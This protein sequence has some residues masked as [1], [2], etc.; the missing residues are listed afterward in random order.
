MSSRVKFGFRAGKFIDQGP[1]EITA[2]NA[3]TGDAVQKQVRVH[4]DGEPASANASS[5][6]LSLT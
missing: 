4:P 2:A 5:K 1:L 6:S 3:S